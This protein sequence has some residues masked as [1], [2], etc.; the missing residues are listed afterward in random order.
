M[1]K[2]LIAGGSGLVG[3]RLTTIL[4]S[5]G[6]EVRW[7]SRQ[8]SQSDAAPKYQWNLSEAYID[9]RALEGI[10][11][12]INLAG[13]GIASGR[14]TAARKKSIIESRT[15]STRLLGTYIQKLGLSLHTYINASAVGYYGHRGDHLLKEDDMP[16]D[17][18][19]SECCIAWEDA[20]DHIIGAFPKSIIRI[21]IVLSTKGG[22]MEKMLIPLKMRTNSY[23][24]DGSQYMSWIHLDDICGIFEYLIDHPT[25]GIFNGVASD[26]MT[27]KALVKSVAD[28]MDVSALLIP[29]PAFGLKLAMGEMASIVLDSTRVSN[30]K[31]KEWG[32]QFQFKTVEEAVA[33][34]A[35]RDL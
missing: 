30:A 22:A 35:A 17:G 11:V 27:N 24:G 10:D 31:I 21:G 9:E 8:A 20:M 16:G 15:M 4:Q 29:A 25:S 3:R 7:L 18:F 19:V 5:K 13:T 23:F 6:H 32:Y 2:I 26:P 33:D 34:L 1:H 12:L 14:W 28:G